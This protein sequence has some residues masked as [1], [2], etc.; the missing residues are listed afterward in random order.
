MALLQYHPYFALPG[1]GMLYV[2]GTGISMSCSGSGSGL[3]STRNWTSLDFWPEFAG[4]YIKMLFNS[5]SAH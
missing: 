3:T 2:C 4:M 1:H 5:K